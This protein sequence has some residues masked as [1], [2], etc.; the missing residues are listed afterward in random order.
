MKKIAL[1]VLLITV[2]VTRADTF[3]GPGSI[4]IAT[5]QAILINTISGL[6]GPNLYFDGM[7]LPTQTYSS[8]QFAIAG[9]HTLSSVDDPPIYITYQILNGSAIQTICLTNQTS[10]SFNQTNSLVV[11]AG[12]TVQFFTP[13]WPGDRY[14]SA[15][16]SPAAS[17]NLYDVFP[18]AQ[19]SQ[20]WYGAPAVAGP[21][22]ITFAVFN[23]SQPLI[24]SYTS[25][26]M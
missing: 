11:P 16:I 24:V 13:F 25:L 8:P 20:S 6:T 18:M 14:C 3:F 19:P 15:L 22:T 17:T 9:P 2:V 7:S 26:S 12:K 5:N 4:N 21:C 23:S 10:G 1:L